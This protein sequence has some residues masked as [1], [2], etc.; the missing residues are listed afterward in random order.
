MCRPLSED[1]ARVLRLLLTPDA[2]GYT[3]LLNQLPFATVAR[4]RVERLPSIAIEVAAG[5]PRAVTKDGPLPVVADVWGEDGG[6]TGL[7][8]AWVKDG[9]LSALEYGWYTDDP[10]TA[11]PASKDVTLTVSHFGRPG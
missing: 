10:P 1:A 9:A 11:W 2:E 3:T 7:I 5:A 6:P 8:L 4:H